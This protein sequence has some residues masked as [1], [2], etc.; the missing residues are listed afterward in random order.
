MEAAGLTIDHD[1]VSTFLRQIRRRASGGDFIQRRVERRSCLRDI[2]I[3]IDAER[4]PADVQYLISTGSA[5]L[6]LKISAQL[7]VAFQYLPPHPPTCPN[8][9]AGCIE[10]Q[11]LT[12]T[13][14]DGPV[15]ALP[16][17]DNLDIA[18]IIGYGNRPTQHLERITTLAMVANTLG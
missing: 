10:C 12:F 16:V 13:L 5:T 9:Q 2:V 3:V 14:E 17:P 18:A 4:T 15:W 7:A 1:S 6:V 11:P 8:S